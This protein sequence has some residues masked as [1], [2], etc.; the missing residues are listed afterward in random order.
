MPEA[1][2]GIYDCVLT[3]KGKAAT[4]LLEKV[5]TSHHA[6]ECVEN[7]GTANIT[8]VSPGVSLGKAAMC[9]S[10]A[11]QR[12]VVESALRSISASKTCDLNRIEW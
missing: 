11:A 9:L 1:D 4:P 7:F 5:L 10:D 2:I 8:G 12:Q 6:N 3:N